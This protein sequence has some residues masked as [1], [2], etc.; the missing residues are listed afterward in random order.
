MIS[1]ESYGKLLDKKKDTILRSAFKHLVLKSLDAPAIWH[2][3]QCRKSEARSLAIAD[4]PPT[5][6]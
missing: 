5:R 6:G 4:M 2:F 3:E 1:W